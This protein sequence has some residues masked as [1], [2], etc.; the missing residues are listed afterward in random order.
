MLVDLHMHS[1]RSDGALPPRALVELAHRNGVT[2]MSLTDHDTME[3]V[4]EA[5]TVARELGIEFISGV[6]ISSRWGGRGI[7]V[8][9]LGLDET[10]EDVT[11]FFD[12]V[13]LRRD[14][15]GR[16]MN[17]CFEKLGIRGAYEGALAL[18]GNKSILSRT[19]FALWLLNEGWVKNYQDA[20]DKYLRPGAPCSV[21]V[22]W[23]TVEESVRFIREKGGLAVLAHPG[24]YHFS[25]DWMVEELLK[26]FKAVGGEAIEVCSGSQSRSDDVRFA[27][28]AQS[29][30]FLASSG[31]DWHSDRSSR[32]KPGEQPQ[33][34]EGVVPVW[35]RFGF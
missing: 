1:N 20:F 5:R 3:G 15:R 13:A 28:L 6:E 19:H 26:H 8:V 31:S 29:M 14:R 30:G 34:P 11:A 24:R 18:A 2:L 25:S 22:D 23:P 35:T 10:R 32:P 17:A 7:H 12:S 16:E 33:L 9:G 27:A 4:G 21:D